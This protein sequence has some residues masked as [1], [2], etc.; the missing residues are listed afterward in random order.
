[1]DRILNAGCGS[2]TYGTDFV[3]INPKRKGVNRCDLNSERLPYKGNTFDKVYSREV[4]AHLHT[5]MHF[6][7]ECHRVLKPNGELYLT[8]DSAGFWGSFGKVYFG[9]YDSSK[10]YGKDDS[11]YYLHTTKTLY[12]L[13]KRAGFR[14]IQV[15]YEII[16]PIGNEPKPL[17]HRIFMRT[18]AVLN[19]RLNPHIVA[20]AFK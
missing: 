5:P 19:K 17:P 3:D 12:N 13:L 20:N 18:I 16:K 1:M 7:K 15:N 9:A 2:D 14:T 10:T 6:L 11:V 8:T 4:I